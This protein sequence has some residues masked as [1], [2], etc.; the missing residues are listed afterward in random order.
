MNER[1]QIAQILSDVWNVYQKEYPLTPAEM[2]QYIKFSD[3][4]THGDIETHFA[5]KAARFF[6][7]ATG[8]HVGENIQRPISSNSITLNPLDTA[9][10]I[11]QGMQRIESPLFSKIE[12]A[13]PG[14]INFIL[15]PQVFSDAIQCARTEEKW[16]SNSL[17]QGKTIM[18]EYT[19]PNPFKEFHIG[20]LM[21]NAIGESVSRLLEYSGS[22][23]LR[24]NSQGDVGL[25]VAKAIWGYR[26]MGENSASEGRHS[27]ARWGRAYKF[28]SAEYERTEEAKTEINN[29][30]QEIFEH[31]VAIQEYKEGREL[32]LSHFEDL[33]KILGTTFD[34]YFFES[35]TGPRGLQIVNAHPEVFEASEGAIIFR[36]E[37]EGLHTRV[38]VNKL[39]LPTYEAKDLG[40]A[41]IKME[42]AIFDTSITITAQEQEEY[43]K[44]MQAALFTIHP[45]WTDKIV[46]MT[47]GM[48]RFADGKMSSRTGNVVT[49]ESLLNDLIESARSRA[50]ESRADDKDILAQQIAVSAIKYQIL[51]QGSGKDIVFDREKALSMEGDSGPY[52]QYAY[53]RTCAIVARATTEGIVGTYDATLV[54]NDLTR[55]VYRFPEVVAHATHLL[56][57]HIVTQYLIALASAFN[58]W[59]AQEQILD[60]T[61][62]AAH[63][64][65][66]VDAVR[67]TLGKGL[68]LLGIKAPEKM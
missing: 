7:G 3:D 58:S 28:G 21:S 15:A 4:L 14:I 17:N 5:F 23:V 63:K 8:S 44:V 49:G 16:G 19:D 27:I 48:M 41:E 59:Y 55:L 29:L 2:L 18:V 26:N 35:E 36:G 31:T 42:K 45:D 53:A 43:F 62:A 9:Q 60:G 47:H 56:E 6:A 66:I 37:K 24:A 13:G 51:K 46:H 52:L 20:H 38:F 64:V 11:V 1:E 40:L 57:P 39:G 12:I 10:A 25:H 54:V 22:K 33:Y 68:W 32:S 67:L 50:S 30:G 65:A 61:P 34:F